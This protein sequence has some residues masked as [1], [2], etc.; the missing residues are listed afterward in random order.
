MELRQLRYF[1][2]VAKREHMTEAAEALHVAQSA[3]SRQIGNLESELGINLFIRQGRSV[4]LTPIGRMFFESTKQALK[5]LDTAT[6]EVDEHL[7]PER[8]TIR[9][10]F[11]ISMAA[12]T[13]P[14]AISAFKERYPEAKFHLKQG[15]YRNLIDEVVNGEF[16]MALLGPVP[17]EELKISGHILFVEEIVA[18]LPLNHPL[19]KKSSI[20]LI[21]LK[22]EH[23]ILLPKGLIFREVIEKACLEQG[24][25]PKVAFEG[26]DV[27]ALKGLVSASLGIT[28][29]PEITLIDNVPRSTVKIPIVNPSVTRSIGVI[30][31]V[32]RPLLPTEMLFLDFLKGFFKNMNS[33]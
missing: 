13:L 27:D 1:M 21:D 8:G 6:R 26:D 33:L 17:K 16:N 2:E 25:S 32:D 5:M 4:R 14:M 11:P 20:R 18:L 9:I 31:P 29:M 3:I 15:T 22:E 30:T 23:F 7:D 12:Y 19:S 24:F 10:A 28:L